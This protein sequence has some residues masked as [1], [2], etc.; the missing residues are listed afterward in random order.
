MALANFDC[1]NARSVIGNCKLNLVNFLYYFQATR[2]SG[3]N[4][5]QPSPK[6]KVAKMK[7]RKEEEVTEEDA[8]PL[9]LIIIRGCL[10]TV[11]KVCHL[12][13]MVLTITK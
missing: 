3:N 13:L 12:Y 9:A 4:E 10:S 2:L 5:P 11:S 8:P 7:I 6:N 1:I